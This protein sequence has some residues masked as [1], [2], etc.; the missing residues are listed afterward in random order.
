MR[1]ND[2]IG[3]LVGLG[4]LALVAMG[5][6]CGDLQ[7]PTAP[8][9]YVAYKS[10]GEI[11]AFLP[12]EM[13]T[14]KSNLQEDTARVTFEPPPAGGKIIMERLSAD[15]GI[16][17]VAWSADPNWTE[18][19]NAGTATNVTVEAFRLP[20]QELLL[21][22]DLSNFETL[23][24]SPTGNLLAVFIPTFNQSPPFQGLEVYAV[25]G[26]TLLWSTVDAA[27]PFAFS[28]D[29]SE[30]YA[31]T[32]AVNALG[33]YDGSTGVAQYEVATEPGDFTLA[34]SPDGAQLITASSTDAT[35]DGRVAQFTFRQLSDGALEQT[36]P[37]VP[38]FDIGT[39]IAVSSDGEHWAATADD[40]Q[41]S[42][43]P[44]IQMWNT[45][46][47][48]LYTLPTSW[49]MTL[50]FSPDGQQ[51]VATPDPGSN[52]PGVSVYNVSDGALLATRSFTADTF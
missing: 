42:L 43:A 51:L 32:V 22:V 46:G 13:V 31:R 18:Y 34:V 49:Y 15:G 47:T 44:S 29:G 12:R 33:A 27:P 30:L 45:A 16:A 28:P 25:D 6:A 40:L 5:A 19:A 20:E 26:G 48:L 9:R 41:N 36:I 50:A 3:R 38:N 17:V 10:D 11:A 24:L 2:R 8:V 23:A 52:A 37:Q 14:L 4:Q 7:T 1:T 35:A 21:S 39:A